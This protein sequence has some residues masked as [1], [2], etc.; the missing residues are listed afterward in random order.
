MLFLT[1]YVRG[2]ISL[3]ETFVTNGKFTFVLKILDT[4]FVS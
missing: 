4:C 2:F 3:S 1:N